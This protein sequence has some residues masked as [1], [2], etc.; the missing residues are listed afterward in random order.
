VNFDAIWSFP[1]PA[2][3]G[4]PPIWLGAKSKYIAARIA[5][6]GDG[7]M[8]IFGREGQASVQQL[9]EECARRGRDC[10]E[11][12]LASFGPPPT[13]EAVAQCLE[14]GYQHLIF[15]V[16]SLEADRLLPKLD[17]LGTLAARMR[18]R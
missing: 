13:E 4:G 18:N 5:E 10:N 9:R 3:S 12:T 16:P 15:L 6:Y 8:P 17:A 7:F 11:I 14:E 2:R 1:K